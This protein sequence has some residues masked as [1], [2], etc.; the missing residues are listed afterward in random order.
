[1]FPVCSQRFSIFASILP[2]YSQLFTISSSFQFLNL[3]LNSLTGSSHTLHA[4]QM[5][6][7]AA[8]TPASLQRFFVS[9]FATHEQYLEENPFFASILGIFNLKGESTHAGAGAAVIV[10]GLDV[11]PL[12]AAEGLGEGLTDVVGFDV[13]SSEGV[14]LGSKL[15]MLLGAELGVSL[16]VSLGSKLGMLLGTSLGISLG[17]SLG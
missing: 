12:G 17:I 6:G 15:G 14:S 16:G 3:N 9:L 7:H 10:I 11:G 5:T 2:T 8:D 1:M 13:G 4:P